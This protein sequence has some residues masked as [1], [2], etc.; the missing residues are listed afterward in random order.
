MRQTSW[1]PALGRLSVAA[2]LA[3]AAALPGA[4][5]AD[6]DAPPAQSHEADAASKKLMAANGLAHRGL[7]KLAADE[8]KE[9][10]AQNPAP[11][12]ATAERYALGLCLY[13]LHDY[14]AA[15]EP[16]QTAL[17]DSKL[18]HRDDALAML[19]YCQLNGK[20]YD[21]AQATFAGLLAKYPRGKQAESASIYR[22]QSLYFG[23]KYKDVE[24]AAKQFIGQY[25]KS[26]EIP[27]AL[28][29]QALSQRAAGQNDAAT[30]SLEQLGRDYPD[31]RYRLDATLLLGQSL[32]SQG[33][34]DAAI[35]Q[36]RRMLADA[37]EARKADAQYSLGLALYKAG[38]YDDAA[39]ELI[40]VIE[41]FPSSAYAKPAKLQLGL[42]QLASGKTADA[43]KS[44]SAVA[45]E[46]TASAPAARYGLA[47]C[48]I[49]DKKYDSARATLDALVGLQPPPANLPQIQFDR[50]A[51]LMGLKKFDEAAGEFAAFSSQ[52]PNSPQAAESEYRQAYCL[53]AQGKYDQSHALCQRLAKLPASAISSPV[54]ELD[55]ENL[56]RMT[57]Y[58]EAQSAFAALAKGSQD[59]AK[60]ARYKLRQGQ[61][62]YYAGKYADAE[63]VLRSVAESA[64]G[65]S[66]DESRQAQ[67]LLGDALLQQGKH[68]QAADVLT[69]YVATAKGEQREARYKLALA[70]SQSKDAGGALSALGPLIQGPVDD[71]WVQRGLLEAG[72]LNYQAKRPEPAAAALHK[73]LA[74]KPLEELIA[75][76]T[77]LLGFIDF[78]A[79]RYAAAAEKWKSV[80]QQ[81]GNP[82]L[83]ADAAFQEAL[84]LKQAGKTD[85]ALDAIQAFARLHPD[86][87][88]RANALAGSALY[89]LAW[90]QRDKDKNI[91]A[92]IQTYRK[93]L[94]LQPDGKLAPAARTELGQL[95]YDDKKYADAAGVLEVVT[96]DKSA[97]PKTASAALY[98][99]GW[100][101]EKL[102]KPD[103]AAPAFISFASAHGDDPQLTPSALLAAA[104]ASAEQEKFDQ[105][106]KSLAQLLAKF[107]E[108]KDAPVAL[109][110]LGEAQAQQQ[111]FDPSRKSYDTFIQKYPKSE[112][113]Y[114]ADFGAG[115]A[116]E[117]LKKYD[118]ARTAYKKVIAASNGEYAARAQFQIGE[119]LLA[120]QKFEPAIKELLAVEDVYGYPKWSA[121]AD[122]EAGRAF[123]QL[124]QPEQAKRQYAQI[125]AKYKDAPEAAAARERLKA[126]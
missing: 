48:D 24:T 64:D 104:G 72:Q 5:A 122:F 15:I 29:F 124:K 31:S 32:E 25:P 108:Y 76:A 82:K 2:V 70:R 66:T 37:P 61:C 100:C 12:Q 80:A 114:R 88:S 35:A 43:R 28:Y 126:M 6:A 41:G 112:F 50:A 121:T 87:A 69:K 75:P 86:D 84:A 125:L 71:P 68:A 109:L 54:G 8:Y 23:K 33:K 22:I 98:T 106:E 45:R 17:K 93:L 57:K 65:K 96:A 91:P 21:E 77:Y 67:F 107:P 36:Y 118:E 42:A 115:W 117:N 59:H 44:L 120:E 102:G 13:Q 27:T 73:L 81:R 39:R 11:Q 110:K 7:Y 51:C 60:A 46:D 97:D 4:R 95:L 85:E 30:A 116:L 52:H 19:G 58:P 9:L 34:L 105:A 20:Q 16:L 63:S 79:R 92:A 78:D 94:K 89:D 90:S 49:A 3:A 40:G 119:T 53:H 10:L 101:Y 113:A 55:A 99:L 62:A 103:K 74:G 26:G 38:K 111:E 47:Q 83:A 18:D 123:E 1:R 56:F 14:P